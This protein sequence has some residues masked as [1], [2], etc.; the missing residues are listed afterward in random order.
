V[1]WHFLQLSLDFIYLFS[2]FYKLLTLFLLFV[3]AFAAQDRSF[4]EEKFFDWMRE[5]DVTFKDGDDFL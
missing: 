2:M 3:G 1:I 5:Y 4:Y